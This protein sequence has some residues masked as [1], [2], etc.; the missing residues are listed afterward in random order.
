MPGGMEN[1]FDI[2]IIGA[3]IAGASL[4]ATL[5]EGRRVLLLEQEGRPGYHTTGRSAAIYTE[6]YGNAP[7]RALTAASRG[8]FE[9]P[10]RGFC[11][12]PLWHPIDT[13]LIGTENQ[14]EAVAALYAEVC[15][16]PGVALV[17]GRDYEARMPLARPGVVRAAVR[18][19]GSMALDVDALYR[20]W[21]RALAAQGARLLTDAPV[22]GLARKGGTWRLKTPAGA[23]TAAVVVNAA[24]A[25]ADA[26]AGMAGARA[27]GLVP[28]R[29]TICV[30]PTPGGVATE[31]W[32]MSVDVEENFYFKP[33]SGGILCSPADET[34]SAPCDASPEEIDIAIGID[35]VQSVIDLPVKRIAS[36]WA[37]LRTFAPDRTPVVG[38]DPGV[39]GFFWLAGQG[40]YGIQTAPAM[41]A[42]A[43]GLIE[44][45][46][47]PDDLLA[48]GLSE[49]VLAP[50]RVQTS[51]NA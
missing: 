21:L 2:A 10:P 25:W 28:L 51:G 31:G 48:R 4:A 34:P 35:R 22:T 44:R 6:T 49:E 14:Q 46:R 42:A 23:F 9:T 29:R 27:Q 33:E 36:K 30:V 1:A 43:A 47:L 18:D 5:A 37:G 20:G 45:G 17:E 7:I 50:G 24:G 16:A 13:F 3:G 38:F 15:S 26:V 41:A 11:D 19:G 8:F 39:E 12:H 40:G 32:P